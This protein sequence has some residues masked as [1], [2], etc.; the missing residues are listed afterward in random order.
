MNN[1]ETASRITD[2]IQN[3]LDAENSPAPALKV[4]TT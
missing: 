3:L 1:V 2:A 4:K